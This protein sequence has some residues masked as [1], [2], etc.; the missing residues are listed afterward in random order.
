[1][2]R[3]ISDTT[4]EEEPETEAIS[5]KDLLELSMGIFYSMEEMHNKMDAILQHLDVKPDKNP[6]NKV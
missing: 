6:D 3:S 5:N 1:M 2:S 4:P